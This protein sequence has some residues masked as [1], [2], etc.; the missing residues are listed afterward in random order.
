MEMKSVKG[1]S[2]SAH[3]WELPTPLRARSEFNSIPT[4]LSTQKP[5]ATPLRNTP[6]HALTSSA[7]Y[8]AG[9]I[10]ED[11]DVSNRKKYFDPNEPDDDF[12]RKFYLSEEGQTTGEEGGDD[13]VFLGDSK[14]FEERELQMKQSRSRGDA[15]IAGVSARRSQLAVD[16]V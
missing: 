9:I 11:D 12:D 8:R 14:K 1:S 7:L 4:P 13:D 15:K 6:K 16:Q 3:E 5:V 10:V 2:S